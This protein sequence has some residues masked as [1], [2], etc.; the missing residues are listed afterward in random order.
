M[1]K[2][3]VA[4]AYIFAQPTWAEEGLVIQFNIEEQAVGSASSEQYINA[5]LMRSNEI[6]TV[7]FHDL[8]SVKVQSTTADMK[9]VNLVITLKDIVDGKPFYVGAKSVDLVVGSTAEFSLQREGRNYKITLDT[10]FGT[11]PSL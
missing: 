3:I 4:I 10:S 6:V 9:A 7:D 5:I 8:Y 1:R 2:Y 11:L